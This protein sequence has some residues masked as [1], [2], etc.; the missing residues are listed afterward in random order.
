[1]LE[2]KRDEKYWER[3]FF[4]RISIGDNSIV[5]LEEIVLEE[6]PPIQANIVEFHL[7]PIEQIQEHHRL[8]TTTK[9][10]KNS[11]IDELWYLGDGETV[12][13]NIITIYGYFRLLESLGGEEF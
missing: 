13:Q 1:M 11:V 2:Y 6:I 4:E 3:E 12:S 5:K 8:G 10:G 9:F 7:H